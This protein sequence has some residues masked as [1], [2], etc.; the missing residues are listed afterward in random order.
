MDENLNQDTTQEAQ[1]RSSST[2]ILIAIGI[3]LLIAA[4]LLY[5]EARDQLQQDRLQ[6]TLESITTQVPNNPAPSHSPTPLQTQ[7]EVEP[8]VYAHPSQFGILILSLREGTDAHLFAYQPILEQLDG[9][10]FGTFPL[11]RLTSGSHQNIT[12]EISPDGRY[13]A[14]SSNRSGFWDIYILDLQ[15]GD[16]E[17][18]TDTA[19]YDANP[20]WSPD[21]LWLVYESYQIDNLEI[22]I[23]DRNHSSGPIPLTRNPAADF[24]PDWSGQGRLISFLSSRSGSLEVWY[25]N[26]DSP[27]EDKAI[28][29]EYPPGEIVKHPNW[30]ADGRYLTWAIITGEGEHSLIT[31]DSH[32][33]DRSPIYTGSGDWPLWA[34]NILYSVVLEPA[35]TYL[36]AYTGTPD[37]SQL[38]LPAVKLPGTLE[39]ISWTSERNYSWFVEQS[40]KAS[41]TP[42]WEP[43]ANPGAGAED[44]LENLIQLRNLEAPY[45]QFIKDTA[46]NFTDLRGAVID[47]AGW[48][49][50][51]TL[52][53]AFVPLGNP[54]PPGVNLTW[55][56][57]GRAMMLNDIPRLANWLLLTREN[58]GSQTYWRVYIRAHNQHGAQGK[59]IQSYAWDLSARYSGKNSDYENGGALTTTVPEGYWVDFTS[60]AESY[61]WKRFPAETFWQ[62]SEKATRYQYFAFTRGLDLEQALN[63]LYS[64]QEIQSIINLSFP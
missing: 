44:G 26:L 53:N 20:S 52:E 15:T 38:L 42:L 49:F 14:F 33:P 9:S 50:L 30:S 28:Q 34:G 35:A 45:P 57:T 2:L 43:I 4:V 16:L 10:G 36:T 63:Q 19:A 12:P 24:A 31:W 21:G 58:Y 8:P 40:Q 37:N 56:Y 22:L 60:L 54:L 64:V 13:V 41:I 6:T 17:Q 39:G 18:F 61:G 46:E 1:A 51:A 62:F 25:A 27:A 7:E 48:D 23:Q 11:T 3:V 32:H 55:L 5:P 47:S 59:P 29:I